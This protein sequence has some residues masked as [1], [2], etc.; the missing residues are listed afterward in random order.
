MSDPFRHAPWDGSS[1]PFTIGMRPIT[2]AS[3]IEVDAH[4]GAYLDEKARLEAVDLSAVFRAEPDTGAAQQELLE[5][6]IA[7]LAA[8]HAETHRRHGDRIEM[9]TA[10]RT[11]DLGASDPPLLTASRLVQEDI[12]LME[13]TDDGWRL[14]AAAL[15]FPSSWRLAGK[16]GRPMAAIHAPVPGFAGRMDA[17]V[18]RIFDSLAPSQP[19]ERFNWSLYDDDRLHYPEPHPKSWRDGTGGLDPARI[20]V[21]VERQ[22]LTKLPRS[23]AVAF[24][25]RVYQGP[26]TGLAGTRSGRLL[27]DDLESLDGPQ[28]AY[29]GWSADADD[30][31]AI[32]RAGAA[33]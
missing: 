22:T 21:R 32:F 18:T 5:A 24:T 25:I 14:A 11:V 31:I 4:F 9:P 13:R 26:A 1:K 19:V 20:H 16:I 29:K 23:R 2:P 10:G 8:H 33:R 17:M 12:C 15:A 28:R 6:L 30:L 27:A 3:W 7:N